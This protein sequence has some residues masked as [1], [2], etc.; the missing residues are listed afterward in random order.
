MILER[1]KRTLGL[2]PRF[3]P[4]DVTPEPEWREF[5]LPF[6]I[7]TGRS[8][9]FSG[10]RGIFIRMKFFATK[11]EEETHDRIIGRIFF[12][13]GSHGP[14]GHA[15]GGMVAYVMDECLGTCAWHNNH[16]CVAAHLEL[17]YREPVPQHE[18]LE[19]EAEIAGIEGRKIF[20]KGRISRIH[21]DGS[22]ELCVESSG[23]FVK[24][25]G[26]LLERFKKKVSQFEEDQVAF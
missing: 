26:E 25:G 23:I 15:H 16:P 21:K 3:S 22:K 18:D 4:P 13:P 8:P 20:T 12:G 2:G 14:P 17:D 19:I 6:G 1:I 11:S 5:H 9:Y 24:V 7:G 10:K